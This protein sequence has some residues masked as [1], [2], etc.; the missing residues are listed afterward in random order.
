MDIQR[1]E[2]GIL[3]TTSIIPRLHFSDS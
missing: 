3:Q 1:G 2:K